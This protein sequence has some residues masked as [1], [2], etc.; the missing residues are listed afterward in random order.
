MNGGSPSMPSVTSARSSS[1][2]R[3]A[4]VGLVPAVAEVVADV[5]A[6]VSVELARAG[7]D[8]CDVF[9]GE[10]R[11]HEEVEDVDAELVARA[12]SVAVGV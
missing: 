2:G 6:D 9:G 8:C 10:A 12:A 5:L 3:C 11:Q 1:T 7:D 4:I